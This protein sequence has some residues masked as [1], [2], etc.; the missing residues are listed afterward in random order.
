M[1]DD[2]NV[3]LISQAAKPAMLKVREYGISHRLQVTLDMRYN[4]S[5]TFISYFFLNGELLKCNSLILSNVVPRRT[6]KMNIC[7]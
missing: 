1:E 4:L 2:L 7:T 5:P 3:V 6:G